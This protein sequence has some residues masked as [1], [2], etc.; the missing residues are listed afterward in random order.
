MINF[1]VYLNQIS[2]FE[3]KFFIIKLVKAMA[4]EQQKIDILG[5]LANF[6]ELQNDQ[7]LNSYLEKAC[8]TFPDNEIEFAKKLIKEKQETCPHNGDKRIKPSLSVSE[9]KFEERCSLCG[10][11]TR[12]N[13]PV[14]EL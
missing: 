7:R 9:I 3:Y 13:V 14:T 5:Q 1:I 10:H 4:N 12:E 8:A 2:S 6:P 11:I